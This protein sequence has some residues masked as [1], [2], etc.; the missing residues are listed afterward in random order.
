MTTVTYEE[1]TTV[2]AAHASL[3]CPGFDVVIA[4]VSAELRRRF[5]SCLVDCQQ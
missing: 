4:M 5:V 2:I 3:S 1:S